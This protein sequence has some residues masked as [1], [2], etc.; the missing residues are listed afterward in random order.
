MSVMCLGSS[1]LGVRV[2]LFGSPLGQ[3]KLFVTLV[4]RVESNYTKDI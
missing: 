4:V 3:R 2:L 1:P